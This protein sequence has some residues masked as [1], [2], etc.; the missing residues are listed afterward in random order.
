VSK[1][2]HGNNDQQETNR[3]SRDGREGTH[4]AEHEGKTPKE[5]VACASTAVVLSEGLRNGINSRC[6]QKPAMAIELASAAWALCRVTTTITDVCASR[7]RTCTGTTH[8]RAAAKRSI[9]ET[10]NAS[11]SFRATKDGRLEDDDGLRASCATLPGSCSS[12]CTSRTVPSRFEYKRLNSNAG[13]PIGNTTT[14]IAENTTH[15]RRAGGPSHA[16]ASSA[17]KNSWSQSNLPHTKVANIAVAARGWVLV[18]LSL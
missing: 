2:C 11:R 16:S 4:V 9:R 5:I 7:R 12:S 3:N 8:H 18:K 10:M 14:I 17:R 13:T 15:P 1:Y 6:K